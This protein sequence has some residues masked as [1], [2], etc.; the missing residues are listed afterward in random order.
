MEE[1]RYRGIVDTIAKAGVT[2]EEAVEAFGKIGRIAAGNIDYDT[3][4]TN[5]QRNPNLKPWEK[6]KLIKE[7]KKDQKKMERNK[8]YNCNGECYT[9]NSMCPKAEICGETAGKEFTATIIATGA[10]VLLPIAVIAMLI[11]L[12]IYH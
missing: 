9:Y 10:T 7:L 6:R 3:E 5:I 12:I 1:S 2:T 4:I 11:L 8:K